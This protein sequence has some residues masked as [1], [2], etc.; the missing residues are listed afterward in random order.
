MYP[1]RP[2]P[3]YLRAL[4]LP[5]P[6][7]TFYGLKQNNAKQQPLLCPLPFPV[8]WLILSFNSTRSNGPTAALDVHVP[9]TPS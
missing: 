1:T 4:T 2:S 8:V 3:G 7:T 5:P 9:P 6:L